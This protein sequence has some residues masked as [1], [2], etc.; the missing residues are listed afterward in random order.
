MNIRQK[1]EVEQRR[2]IAEAPKQYRAELQRLHD[3][4]DDEG[5]DA[6]LQE[7]YS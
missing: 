1:W 6:L 3:A 7:I 4:D 5:F 2:I